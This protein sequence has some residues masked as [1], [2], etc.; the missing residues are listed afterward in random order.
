VRK[1]YRAIGAT[2]AIMAIGTTMAGIRVL[3]GVP[4]DGVDDLWAGPD[5][6]TD[7]GDGGT[8]GDAEEVVN[9]AVARVGIIVMVV[10]PS[11][12]MVLIGDPF[13]NSVFTAKDVVVVRVLSRMVFD[14]RICEG[15]RLGRSSRF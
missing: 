4:L 2:R 6:C 14:G 8:G 5:G 3:R 15:S 7:E 1:K 10:S 13:W 9:D 12:K 11:T